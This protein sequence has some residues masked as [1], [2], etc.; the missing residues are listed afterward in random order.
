MK[1]EELKENKAVF[2][3]LF[4][5]G[6][7]YA[8]YGSGITAVFQG[9]GVIVFWEEEFAKAAP[10]EPENLISHLYPEPVTVVPTKELEALRELVKVQKELIEQTRYL[11]IDECSDS[12]TEDL[13]YKIKHL[14]SLLNHDK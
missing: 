9:R 1:L 12:V 10:K 8:V 6:R 3:P 11:S 5:K 13:E 7:V 14:E 4:G 2:H